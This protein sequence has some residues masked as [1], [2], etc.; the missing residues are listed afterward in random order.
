VPNQPATPLRSFR[1]SDEIWL[2]ALQVAGERNE[3]LTDV[4]NAALVR[5]ARTY[6]HGLA[7]TFDRLELL[8]PLD[9]RDAELWRAAEEKAS[10]AGTDLGTVLRTYLERYVADR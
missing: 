1:S 10:A 2:P 5:Y 7:A 8:S 4:L 3:T 6:G 9:E